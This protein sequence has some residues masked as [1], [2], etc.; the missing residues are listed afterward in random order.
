MEMPGEGGRERAVC[1][2]SV[3]QGPVLPPRYI[4]LSPLICTGHA[5]PF[6]DEFVLK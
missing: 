3:P 6:P 5:V 2:A 4:K 1:A